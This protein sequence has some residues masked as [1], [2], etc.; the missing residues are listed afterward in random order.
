[1]AHVAKQCD[2]DLAQPAILP[3]YVLP[4]PKRMLCVHRYECDVAVALPEFVE[5]VLKSENLSWAYE[6]EGSRDEEQNEPLLPCVGDIGRQA[7][8]CKALVK[9]EK[10]KKQ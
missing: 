7:D 10:E 2:L 1:M 8:F 9:S 4:V 6:A 5:T 3:R